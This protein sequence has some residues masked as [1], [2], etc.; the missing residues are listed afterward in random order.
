MSVELA[1]RHKVGLSLEHPLLLANCTA[2]LLSLCDHTVVGAV[3]AAEIGSR[4]RAP[5]RVGERPGGFLWEEGRG[6]NS[7]QG[8]RRLLR[9]AGSLPVLGRVL[10]AEARGAARAAGRLQQEG[11]Q[12][13][14]LDLLPGDLR[15]AE[16][17]LT[18]V[19]RAT[20]L[21]L[22]AQVPLWE[23]VPYARACEAEG[24]DALVVAGPPRGLAAF[25]DP[26]SPKIVEVH[27]PLLHPLFLLAVQQVARAVTIPLIARGGL[28]TA[29][30]A[31]AFLAQGA[32]AV[33][34]D[35][36]ALVEPAAVAEIGHSLSPDDQPRQAPEEGVGAD[37]Q[38]GREGP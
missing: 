38:R 18:A 32:A 28:L 10:G 7:L 15:Q 17:V 36:L 26:H 2:E 29:A 16:E 14:V 4:A 35:S 24:A 27:G 12:A 34:I 6:V 22:L 25:D 19:R 37:A 33:T 30:D 9:V 31:Q 13:L 1:P 3:I 21:P 20:D 11:V 5:R 23:A 8:L